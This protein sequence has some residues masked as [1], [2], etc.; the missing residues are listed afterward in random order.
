MAAADQFVHLHVH[1]DHSL[2]DGCCRIESLIKRTLALGMPAIALTDHGNLFGSIEFYQKAKDAGVKPLL[3]CEVYIVYDHAMSDRPRRER[4]QP[5]AR[6]E[7]DQVQRRDPSDFPKYK[8]HHKGVIARNLKGYRNLSKLVSLAH[9]EGM[10]YRP[11]VDLDKL[12]AHSEGLIGF[13]GCLNGVVPQFLLYNDYAKAREAVGKFVDIFGQE[14][15]FIELQDHGIPIQK[16]LF[17]ELLRLA[18]EFNLK[19]VCTNDVHYVRREDW[20]A[21]DSLLCIQ[22]GKRLSDEERLRYPC[23]EFYLKS[24]EEM[25]EIF[26]EFPE[27][28]TNTRA[29]ADMCELEIPF[30]EN[31]N[32]IFKKPEEIKFKPDQD[33][34]ERILDIYVAEKAKLNVQKES[35]DQAIK[36]EVHRNDLRE[37]GLFLFD[38]C[39]R[40]LLDRYGV[41]YENAPRRSDGHQKKKSEFSQMVSRKLDYELA[42]I[43]GTG[44]LDYFLIVWDFIYWARQK[45]IPVGPGR[46]SGVGC[47]VSYLLKITDI[48][49]LRFGLLFERMLH[50]ERVSPPDFDLDFCMRRR[51]EV[52]DFVREKYGEDHVAHIIT[53]GTFGAKMSIRDLARVNDVPFADAD[54]LAKMIPD[55]LNVSI[56]DSINRSRELQNEISGNTVTKSIV[57]QGQVIEGMV[58]N[59]G[60]HACGMIIGDQPITNLVPVTLQEGDLTT[61]YSKGPIEDLG[62]LKMDFLGLKTLTVIADT[63]EHIRRIRENPEFDIESISLDDPKTFALLNS[64]QTTGVFQLESRGMQTLCCQ[65]GMSRFEE[66]IA[67]IALYRPGP[68]QDIPKYIKGKKDPSTIQSLHPLLQEVVNETHGILVYQEQVMEAARIIA[69]Y[70]LGEADILRLAM[71][72]KIQSVMDSQR[73]NFVRGAKNHN[74]IDSG[75]ALRIFETLEKFA[76]YGF[77]KSHSAA[78]AMLSY[79][80]AFL[81]ANYPV[82][83]MAALLSSELGNSDKVSRFV[84][85]SASQ[86]VPVLSPD[87]NE[88]RESFTP[89]LNGDPSANGSQTGSIRFG[90]AAIKGVG[91]SAS[92]KIIEERERAG[93]FGSFKDFTLRVDSRSVNRRVMEHLIRSGAF[94]SLGD[95]RGHLL[96]ELDTILG[97]AAAIQR[98]L[99]RGQGNFFDLMGNAENEISKEIE[100]KKGPSPS[101]KNGSEK[102]MDEILKDEKEL[103]GFYVSGHP[104]DIFCGL[105]EPINTFQNSNLRGTND[106]T[107]FRLCGV[108]S[109]LTK[110]LTRKDNRPWAILELATR[111]ATF[112]IN[113]FAEAYEKFDPSI[114]PGNIVLVTGVLL[115]R[116]DDYRLSADSVSILNRFPSRLIKQIDWI[117]EPNEKAND[118]L[119]NLTTSIM[120]EPGPT[121]LRIG[122][123]AED[124][125][126]VFSDIAQ[127]LTWNVTPRGF[128]E[129]RNHPAVVGAFVNVKTP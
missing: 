26:S 24:V 111:K 71:G 89:I 11:R 20:N 69:G 63:E 117:L 8:I 23:P 128:N 122:F 33:N 21:H 38:L 9:T 48:D 29:V 98:D 16:N 91:D 88:S 101:R 76:T 3:G 18:K 103:L 92:Q 82:E 104:L 36:P 53:F 35:S 42:I 59:T 7:F 72:K 5:N 4:R 68:M 75:E 97:E 62:L 116:A 121:R 94:D 37:N 110:K 74:D 100:G 112:S 118:F 85:E 61:Q 44:F 81:K 34:L 105:D 119:S 95:H 70:T 86:N 10:Y 22:T 77:T 25:G 40:G 12:A 30:G 49:P 55:E 102:P 1:S 126:A 28:I 50:L 90:L 99:A 66:I 41:K 46:G 106:R 127:S 52:V 109:T 80:T 107:P 51:D 32:P 108:V 120:E 19:V 93:D 73:E 60:K 83:F 39:K 57:E 67:L 17:P 6:E 54:R 125:H 31:H 2:L 13:S 65:I 43:I 78:Y 27:A 45:K 115:N 64:G 87:I 113:I 79:R 124:H 58:R 129:L 84:D 123:L 15:Y 114:L 56:D 47:I 14:N 96:E